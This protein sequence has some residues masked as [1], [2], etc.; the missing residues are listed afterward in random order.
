MRFCEIHPLVRFARYLEPNDTGPFLCPY[1]CRLFYV[2]KGSASVFAGGKEFIL[3]ETDGV[4]INSGVVY[5]VLQAEEETK[6]LAFNFDFT[7]RRAEMDAPVPPAAPEKFVEN[8]ILEHVTFSDAPDFNR[9]VPVFG[10][11]R[12]E[13]LLLKAY[14]EFGKNLLYSKT[15]SG[16]YLALFLA[17]CARNLS[18]AGSGTGSD[19][20]DKIIGYLHENYSGNITNSRLAELFHYHPNYMNSLIRAKT[21]MSLRRYLLNIRISKAVTLLETTNLSVTQI[22]QEV[23]FCDISYF[24]NY[25][26]KITGRSPKEFRNK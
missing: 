21:G 11:G 6:V 16:A 5:R 10:M 15:S 18:D 8:H 19:A 25:F 22:A 12:F 3:R 7:F 14:C 2:K 26:K 23:G 20:A 17:E 9:A 1:D 13:E 24:S 4:V